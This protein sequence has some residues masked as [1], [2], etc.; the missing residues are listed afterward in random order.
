MLA[1]FLYFW[2]V[3]RSFHSPMLT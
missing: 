3:S 1:H 2:P